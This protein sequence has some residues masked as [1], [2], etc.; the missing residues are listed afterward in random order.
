MTCELL[1]HCDLIFGFLKCAIPED[2]VDVDLQVHTLQ[3]IYTLR[4]D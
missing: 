3:G 4:E 2:T 1:T